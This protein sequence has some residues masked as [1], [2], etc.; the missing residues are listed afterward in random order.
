MTDPKISDTDLRQLLTNF[1]TIAVVGLSA[2]PD[3]ASHRAAAYLQRHGFRVILVNP[4]ADEI[5]GQR[6]YPD[7]MSIPEPVDI[8]DVFRRPEFLPEIARQAVAIHARVLWMQKGI[9]SEGA[10]LIALEGGLTV[11]EDT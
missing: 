1:H 10:A 8:V 7:L 4:K 11:V 6:S 2:N 3:K 5:L 9:K